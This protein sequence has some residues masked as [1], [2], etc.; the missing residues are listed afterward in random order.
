MLGLLFNVLDWRK[1]L[2]A[3][4]GSVTKGDKVDDVV[5]HFQDCRIAAVNDGNAGRPARS[6]DGQTTRKNHKWIPGWLGPM[7]STFSN[8]MKQNKWILT[9]SMMISIRPS[10]L[11]CIP[12]CLLDLLWLQKKFK[13]KGRRI[14]WNG[15]SA[16]KRRGHF[17]ARTRN[18]KQRTVRIGDRN[19]SRPRASS[20]VPRVQRS[21]SVSANQLLAVRQPRNGTK[22]LV[23]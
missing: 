8:N 3:G 4:P 21:V 20:D 22:R 2:T 14:P 18:A 5:L 15:K 23:G 1:K 7:I 11:L 12:V 10:E 13:K 6:I 17:V 16:I 9:R 19:R